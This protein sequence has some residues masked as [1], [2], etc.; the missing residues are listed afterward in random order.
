MAKREKQILTK[1]EI[2]R[3]RRRQET[4]KRSERKVQRV[5]SAPARQDTTVFV[6]RGV[7]GTPVVQ[8][9]R[10]QARRKVALP[11]QSGSEVNLPGLPLIHPGWRL[12]SGFVS[13]V[14]LV[15]LILMNTSSMLDINTVNIQGLRRVNSA[16]VS[17]VLNLQGKAVY[18]VAPQ[19]ILEDLQ[20]AFPEFYDIDVSVELPA[21]VNIQVN[22]RQPVI[23]W[24]YENLSVWIDQDGGVFPQR[25][26]ADDLITVLAN[27][28]PR[29]LQVPM[30][31]EEIAAAKQNMTEAEI[32][33]AEWM[34]DG[35]VDPKLVQ[36]ILYL[37]QH[38]SDA[39][40]ISYR[41][42]DGF[43][44]HDTQQDWNVYFG[45]YLD[46]LDQKLLLYE[47]IRN[48]VLDQGLHPGMISVAYTRAP[49]Y[50]LEQ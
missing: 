25:G 29:R 20:A 47:F 22:E 12:L 33:A 1:A 2:V 5:Q 23:A 27:T 35:P 39:K 43:G 14:L 6:R 9:T 11:L 32:E 31:D 21:A 10:T 34:K 26:T 37:S 16:D 46:N 18:T 38:L 19:V 28:A 4:P 40:Q 7:T 44:W 50:R 8:R 17:S 24:Q 13:I 45:H 3:Q 42:D 15:F 41:T 48:Y 49:F 30:S 36:Q